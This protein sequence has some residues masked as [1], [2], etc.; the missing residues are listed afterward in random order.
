MSILYFY[1]SKF[2]FHLYSS[3]VR[4]R[5][6]EN[7]PN[8]ADRNTRGRAIHTMCVNRW[9]R[10]SHRLLLHG[11]KQSVLSVGRRSYRDT[12]RWVSET[13]TAD[14]MQTSR[15]RHFQLAERIILQLLDGS[16]FEMWHQF[17]IGH[18]ANGIREWRLDRL[19][20]QRI[21]NL[22]LFM[23]TINANNKSIGLHSSFF[24]D[25]HRKCRSPVYRLV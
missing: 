22:W 6:C 18:C 15:Y 12:V 23:C 13:Q 9:R 20:S 8:S 14:Q 17:E 3:A 16:R 7:W 11:R 1:D 2:I 4:C 25:F 21:G 5:F 24:C 10:R 19:H